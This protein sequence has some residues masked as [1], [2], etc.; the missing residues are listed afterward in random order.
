MRMRRYCA[1]PKV[2]GCGADVEVEVVF[3]LSVT[4]SSR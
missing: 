3:W 4:T 2:C 1:G